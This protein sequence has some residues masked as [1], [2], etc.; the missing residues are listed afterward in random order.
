V[1]FFYQDD[2]QAGFVTGNFADSEMLTLGGIL[3]FFAR[4]TGIHTK[5]GIY[6]TEFKNAGQEWCDADPA[7]YTDDP[8]SRQCDEHQSGDDAHRTICAANIGFDVH[9]ELL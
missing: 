9:F 6:R 5:R 7:P 1:G 4:W 3:L 2:K 8:G